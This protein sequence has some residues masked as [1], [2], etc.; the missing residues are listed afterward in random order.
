[1]PF[2]S[3]VLDML[4]MEFSCMLIL[5]AKEFPLIS[6][7]PLLTMPKSLSPGT[8]TGFQLFASFQVEDEDP[9]HS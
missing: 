4:T 5:P 8:P 9:V 7:S 3:D 2:N 6:I 1:M